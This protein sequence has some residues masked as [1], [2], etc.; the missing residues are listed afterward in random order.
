MDLLGFE[1]HQQ[2]WILQRNQ[3]QF[4]KAQILAVR[5]NSVET[6]RLLE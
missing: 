2:Q 4:E 6:T 5:Q 3:L 1:L